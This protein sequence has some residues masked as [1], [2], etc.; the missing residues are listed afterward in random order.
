MSVAPRLSTAR[1]V[2]R[3]PT[4]ADAQR[5]LRFRVDNQAHLAA[6]EPLRDESWYTLTRCVR[7][8]VD[9]AE[10]AR[11]DRAYPLL[12]FSP[13]ENEILASVTFANIMRGPFQACLLGYGVA[14]EQQGKGLMTEV[15]QAGL[16][17]AFGELDLHRVMANYLPHNERSGRLL[18]RLG[19]EKEG[20]APRYLK[21]AGQW[22]DHVL[23]AKVRGDPC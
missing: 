21:I 5:L 1:S 13:D 19:F 6:W 12:V 17:W 3:L 8:I 9:G 2:L 23:T 14:A 15:L 16:E 22:Q 10:A 4:A 11:L 18:A 20:Y 7:S